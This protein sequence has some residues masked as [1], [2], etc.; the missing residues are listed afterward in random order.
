MPRTR[1]APASSPPSTRPSHS[2]PFVKKRFSPPPSAG[3]AAWPPRSFSAACSIAAW[4]TRPR[5]TTRRCTRCSVAVEPGW[6]SWRDAGSRWPQSRVPRSDSFAADMIRGV[7]GRLVTASFARE[8]LPNLPG[9]APIPVESSRELAGWARR[10]E[11]ATG[12]ASSV[13]VIADAVL[14]PLLRLL[15]FAVVSRSDTVA[16]SLLQVLSGAG[17]NVVALAVGWNEP[18]ARSWRTAV[19]HTIAADSAWC[20]CCNGT[21]LRIVDARRTWSREFL[22]FDVAALGGDVEAQALLWSVARADAMAQEPPVLDRAVQLSARHGVEVCR[23]LG[24]GMIDA[25][26]LVLGALAHR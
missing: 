20:F 14:V 24:G 13:R 17:A 2:P 15:G 4:S 25:L 8:V 6:Q 22:E 3:M 9:A 16:E 11:A 10:A 21:A 23:A 26:R 7:A 19:L 12:P 5:R 1:C 18:L